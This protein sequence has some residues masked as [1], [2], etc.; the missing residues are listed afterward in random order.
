[1]KDS[2]DT[3][4][5]STEPSVPAGYDDYRSI[6]VVATNSV[7]QQPNRQQA[8]QQVSSYGQSQ[9][10]TI[11]PIQSFGFQNQTYQQPK[12]ESGY[13]TATPSDVYAPV[14]PQT[15]YQP[16]SRLNNADSHTVSY[17]QP[18]GYV[19]S[20]ERDESLYSA[21]SPV[22]TKPDLSQPVGGTQKLFS[23]GESIETSGKRQY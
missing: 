23:L 17:S 2:R 14:Q 12:I 22:T 19:E 7:Y 15:H 16:R 18:N 10:A 21:I 3:Q 11:D 8:F 5:Q 1:M 4:F 13:Q 20:A 6:P 9:A